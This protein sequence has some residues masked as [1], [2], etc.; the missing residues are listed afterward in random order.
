MPSY[1]YRSLLKTARTATKFKKTRWS[2]VQERTSSAE[3]V[4]DTPSE[5]GDSGILDL[6][7]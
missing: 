5:S 3:P 1:F 6:Q 7:E 2:N 4:A